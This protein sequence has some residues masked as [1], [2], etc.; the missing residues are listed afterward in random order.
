MARACECERN[1]T[2][3][4]RVLAGEYCR[5]VAAEYGLTRNRVQQIVHRVCVQLNPYYY[6]GHYRPSLWQLRDDRQQLVL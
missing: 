2:I 5:V 1:L 4:R 3:T 6:A